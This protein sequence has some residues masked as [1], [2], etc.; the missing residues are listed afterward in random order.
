[1]AVPIVFDVD[2]TVL[3]KFIQALIVPVLMAFVAFMAG[4]LFG[5]NIELDNAAQIGGS[6]IPL[7]LIIIVGGIGEEIGW[8]SFLKTTLEKKYP[9]LVSSIIVG[10]MWGLWH[11][12]RWNLGII[13]MLVMIL[14]T[15]SS[16][17]VMALILKD[18]NNNIIISTAFHGSSNIGFQIFLGTRFRETKI[19][20]LTA[21]TM[22]VIAIVMVIINRKYYLNQKN[23]A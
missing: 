20:L 22:L 15:V 13:F 23:V 18:T 4:N 1:M 21:V 10:I 9:V 19:M 11:I 14:R 17:I 12:D 5:M 16:S 7:I 3:I 6:L 2:K 8:R